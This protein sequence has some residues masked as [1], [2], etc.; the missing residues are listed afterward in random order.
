MENRINVEV[1]KCKTGDILAEDIYNCNN[2][3]IIG[4]NTVINPFIKSKLVQF[5]VYNVKIYHGNDEDKKYNEFKKEYKDTILKIKKLILGI[6]SEGNIDAE[7]LINSAEVI[8]SKIFEADYIIKYI[9]ELRNGDEYTFTH[10]VNVAFY[11]MLTGKWMKLPENNIKEL[12]QA[13]I[14]HDIGKLKVE[15]KILNKPGKLTDEEF[16]EMKNHV[17]YGYDML[18]N[19]DDI[20][21]DIKKG[22]LMHH[23]RVDGTGYPTGAKKNEINLYA[24]I[25][26]IADTYDAMTSNRVYKRKVTPFDSFKMFLTSG[27]RI[28]DIGIINVFLNNIVPFYIGANVKL[29]DERRGKIVYIPPYDI[30]SPVINI[31]NE[32]LDFSKKKDL[33][34]IDVIM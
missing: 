7:E 9:N 2:L 17:A 29:N 18:K 21:D 14:L 15:D 31:N 11:S 20:N 28:Y 6:F 13:G 19:N 25:I 4:K 26:A 8:Y 5:G 30:L 1:S 33:S 12:I 10:S 34:I 23:E 16:E 22:I 24:K 27:I 32:Y 3:K